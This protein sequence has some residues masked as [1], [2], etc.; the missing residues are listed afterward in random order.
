MDFENARKSHTHFCF[1]HLF[2]Y[3]N[4]TKANYLFSVYYFNTIGS[5]NTVKSGKLVAI[6]QPRVTM[7]Y[8]L[9]R[10]G[11]GGFVERPF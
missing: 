7:T 4:C 9:A 11:L 2:F 8:P 1:L 5:L 10:K 6:Y 3:N